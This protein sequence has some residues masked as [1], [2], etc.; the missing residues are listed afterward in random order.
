[1]TE[2]SLWFKDLGLL[3]FTFLLLAIIGII[4]TIITFVRGK[5]EK[6]PFFKIKSFNIVGDNI[7]SL[8]NL[9]VKFKN[10]SID[11]LTSTQVAIFNLG[12]LAIKKEDIPNRDKLRI[13]A[14]KDVQILDYKI[15]YVK[16]EI[17]NFILSSSTNAL[18]VEFDFFENKEGIV[19]QIYHN[20]KSS[21]DL[22]LKGTIINSKKIRDADYRMSSAK[23]GKML[24][25]FMDRTPR[26]LIILMLPFVLI[27]IIINVFEHLI[28]GNYNLPKEYD[29]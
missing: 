9:D 28:R 15:K 22:E 27:F 7:T 18:I 12:R 14:K 21:N 20:G 4:V 24:L 13:E 23:L 8:E 6:L 11:N 1:M 5:Q 16:N 2:I 25:I 3:N 10:K 17:N 19:I 26:P 29:L